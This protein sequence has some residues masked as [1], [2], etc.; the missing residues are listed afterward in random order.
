MRW[1]RQAMTSGDVAGYLGAREGR[2]TVARLSG[3]GFWH[4]LYLASV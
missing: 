2:G 3:T 1:K 4:A